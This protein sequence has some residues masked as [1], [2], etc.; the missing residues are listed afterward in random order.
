MLRKSLV[1]AG[2]LFVEVSSETM[3]AAILVDVRCLD[4]ISP[5]LTIN[6]ATDAEIHRGDRRIIHWAAENPNGDREKKISTHLL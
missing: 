2:C 4:A 3:K 1:V 6:K 5:W